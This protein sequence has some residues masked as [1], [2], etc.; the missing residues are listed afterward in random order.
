MAKE[1]RSIKVKGDLTIENSG[2][3]SLSG[4]VHHAVQSL[5]GSNPELAKLLADLEAKLAAA[6]EL[7]HDDKALA[8]EK[9]AEIA[10]AA[11]AP[12]QDGV[13][14]KAG[15]AALMTLKGLA[16]AL[17]DVAKVIEAVGKAMDA[18]GKL[19]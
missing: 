19:G 3:F 2:T 10:Q 15:R 6:P 7:S 9:V 8:S 12:T 4:D 16:G 5:A 18:V 13:L 11:A 14:R 1:D 17:P